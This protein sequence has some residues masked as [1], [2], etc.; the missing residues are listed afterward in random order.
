MGRK[1]KNTSLECVPFMI[2][3]FTRCYESKERLCISQLRVSF[4]VVTNS[5]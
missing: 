1:L 3:E 2:E 5:P 4:A